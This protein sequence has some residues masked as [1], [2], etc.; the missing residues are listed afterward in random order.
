VLNNWR[1]VSDKHGVAIGLGAYDVHYTNTARSPGPV[2]DHN[3]LAQYR[4]QLTGNL[5][6][7]DVCSSAGSIRND[8][9][10]W[11]RGVI[12]SGGCTGKRGRKACCG[13]RYPTQN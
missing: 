1:A 3:L 11:A 5:P 10:D 8:E 2:F 4:G 12:V 9:M 6:S 7:H 13:Q